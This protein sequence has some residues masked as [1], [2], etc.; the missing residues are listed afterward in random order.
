MNFKN[1][2]SNY[3]LSFLVEKFINIETQEDNT[4][5]IESYSLAKYGSIKDIKVFANIIVKNFFRLLEEGNNSLT[6]L[7]EI[8][9]AN[10][11]FI[12]LMTP[13]YRNIKASANIMFDLAL[14]IINTKLT[15]LNYPKIAKL[16][17]P[18]LASPCENY[19]TLIEEERKQ[20]ALTTDHILPD[21]EFYEG[22]RIHV[23]YGDD[24]HITGASSD[25]A[26]LS[27]L[28][29]G[30][31]SFIS[32]YSI[33]IDHEVAFHNP[34]IEEKINLSKVTG[35]L[36]SSALE[37]FEQEDFIPVLRSLRLILNESNKSTLSNFISKVPNKNLLKIYIAY[38]NNES[39]DNEKYNDS[40]S[41]I[42]DYLVKNKLIKN[43]GNLIGELYEL[44]KCN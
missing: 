2:I 13:G 25:R 32:I 17:L 24:I 12:V 26:R 11:D 23:I 31:L 18:R 43:D 33:I 4:H 9:K 15:L 5:L 27:A 29:N 40:I 22:R 21:K 14:P 35:K 3:Y 34:A 37:I 20:V 38:M 10:D 8:A 28:K 42:R 30:A 44:W 36:D 7:L 1:K 16:K 19:A 6:S 41:I 39:L